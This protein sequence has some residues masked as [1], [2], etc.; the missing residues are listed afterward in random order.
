LLKV[1]FIG[2]DGGAD[3]FRR[4]FRD[5]AG[6]GLRPRQ[7]GFDLRHS[8]NVGLIREKFGYRFVPKQWP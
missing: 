2:P 1:D 3:L 5:D 4:A 8:S 6:F 7:S